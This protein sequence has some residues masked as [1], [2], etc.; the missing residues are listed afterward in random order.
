MV[1]EFFKTLVESIC[2]SEERKRIRDMNRHWHVQLSARIPHGIKSWIINLHQSP[3]SD[4]LSAV[5]TKRFED[6]QA[7]STIEMRLLVAISL[8]FRII[9]FIKPRVRRFGEGIEASGKGVTIFVH[10]V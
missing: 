4:V 9:Q 6:L 1:V 8:E 5:K 3:R 2:R 10:C 7:A